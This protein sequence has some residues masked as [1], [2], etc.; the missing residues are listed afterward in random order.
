MIRDNGKFMLYFP[1]G[2]EFIVAF[3]GG[4]IGNTTRNIIISRIKAFPREIGD[5][6]A[7]PSYM[8]AGVL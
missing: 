3:N 7:M 8:A 1:L 4:Q 5:Q 2:G 6:L